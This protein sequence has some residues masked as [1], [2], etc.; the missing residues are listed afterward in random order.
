MKLILPLLLLA[1][2]AS[3]AGDPAGFHVWSAADI[4]TMGKTLTQKAGAQHLATTTLATTGNHSFL[5]IARTGSGEAEFHQTQADV[6]IV[7]TGEAILVYGGEVVDGKTTAPNEIRG[8]SIRNGIEKKVLPGDV[9]HI[10]A[11][12]PHQVKVEAGKAITYMTVKVT[13]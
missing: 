12:T 10:P 6:M 2:L 1:G 4:K 9:I 7:E 5:M 8:P 3:S 11:K 13:E